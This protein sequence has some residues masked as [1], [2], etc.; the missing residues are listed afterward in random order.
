MLE[1]VDQDRGLLRGVLGGVQSC[2]LLLKRRCVGTE[3][4]QRINGCK[5]SIV[6]F[7]CVGEFNELNQK[8]TCF[9]FLLLDCFDGD[10]G[11]YVCD[12]KNG[13]R[14]IGVTGVESIGHVCNVA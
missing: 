12:G 2:L 3:D 10:V 9:A 5:N 11:N 6:G 14:R 1:R 13:G 8:V 4:E 7:L